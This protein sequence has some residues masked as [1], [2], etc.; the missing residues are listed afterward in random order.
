MLST[1]A[2]AT[3]STNTGA[4]AITRTPSPNSVIIRPLMSGSACTRPVVIAR[5]VRMPPTMIPATPPAP[6]SPVSTPRAA[7]PVP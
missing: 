7:S 5:C 4:V 3:D 1:A 6:Y 2:A